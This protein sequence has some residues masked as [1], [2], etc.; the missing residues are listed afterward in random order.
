M[1]YN[2]E[3]DYADSIYE[4]MADHAKDVERKSEEAKKH[5]QE[6]DHTNNMTIKSRLNDPR[7]CIVCSRHACGLAVGSPRRL[8]WYCTD[9]GPDLS[10]EAMMS[11]RF[12]ETEVAA[13]KAVAELCVLPE[14]VLT[15][16][17]LPQFV[18]W[19]VD[20]F[21]SELRRILKQEMVDV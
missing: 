19:C 10:T 9:C 1:G 3:R 20:E 7:L 6:R 5:H 12:D 18:K 13:C 4:S 14:I 21:G 11:N 17:E 8:G 16:D 2:S 15:K